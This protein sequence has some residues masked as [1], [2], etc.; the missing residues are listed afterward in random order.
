MSSRKKTVEEKIA[1]LEETVKCLR[2][3]L[4]MCKVTREDCLVI[5][6]T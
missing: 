2:I 3:E 5:Y 1:D 6:T 4:K